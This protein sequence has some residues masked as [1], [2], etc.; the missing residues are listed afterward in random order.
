V[1]RR[2]EELLEGA[3][4][5]LGAIESAIAEPY[6]AEGLYRIFAAG[7]LPAPY[8]WAR[9]EEFPE[10][11]RWRT[12]FAKGGVQVVDEAGRPVAAS[13]R[14][15]AAAAEAARRSPPAAARAAG[16]SRC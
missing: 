9:R 13:H 1:Q 7:F 11:V 12:S 4:T 5:V 2:T 8:L 15:A 6:T 16:G 14:A 3:R 10:A